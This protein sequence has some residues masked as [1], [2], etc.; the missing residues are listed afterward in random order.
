M[1]LQLDIDGCQEFD[2]IV[3]AIEAEGPDYV[4]YKFKGMDNYTMRKLISESGVPFYAVINPH[5][6]DET[7]GVQEV[8][9][10]AIDAGVVGIELVFKARSMKFPDW[11]RYTHGIPS[12]IKM[13]CMYEIE[14][15]RDWLALKRT[16]VK[17]SR[18]ALDYIRVVLGP[19][20]AYRF[21]PQSCR[22]M[23]HEAGMVRGS[24]FEFIPSPNILEA[25][26]GTAQNKS[27]QLDSSGNKH[28]SRW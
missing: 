7:L 16:T 23:I 18:S 11:L 22:K 2:R 27:W 24:N 5:T 12:E 6:L 26:Y 17:C 8:I 13:G 28:P 19:S 21:T 15:N 14:S 3:P 9:D 4:L 10:N 25:V 20:P 1:T